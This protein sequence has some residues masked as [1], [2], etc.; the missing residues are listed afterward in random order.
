[1]RKYFLC[2]FLGLLTVL[3][4]GGQETLCSFEQ[5]LPVFDE[6]NDLDY[7]GKGGVSHFLLP[8]V[9]MGA[10]SSSGYHGFDLSFST[11]GFVTSG[12]GLYQYWFNPTHKGWYLGCGAGLNYAI[13]HLWSD[14]W[15]SVAYPT[16]EQSVG[17]QWKGE[18]RAIFLQLELSEVI[19]GLGNTPVIPFPGLSC[20]V[21]F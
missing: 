6:R 10:R 2:L 9:G 18:S 12:K 21:K 17:Y 20:G 15:I 5:H 13:V 19:I 7:Y 16:L 11:C 3:E 4:L 8:T 14:L 1:M